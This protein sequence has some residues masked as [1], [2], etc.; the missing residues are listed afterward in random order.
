[1]SKEGVPLQYD[2]FSGDLVDNRTRKQKKA[3]CQKGQ[4]QQ[5]VMFSQREVAQFGVRSNP[6]MSLSEHTKLVLISEDPRTPEEI[7]RDIQREIEAQ[8]HHLFTEHPE[9]YEPSPDTKLENL[10]EDKI[11]DTPM[12]NGTKKR[13]PDASK[14]TI[15]FDLVR[16]SEENAETIW[17]APPYDTAYLTQIAA[18]VL[19]AQ[20]IG[21]TQPEITAA[22][23]I[24]QH[25][26]N[27]RKTL[28]L[29][30]QPLSQ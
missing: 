6:Q 23:Q 2:L 21:L 1:M 11:G 15:Y 10:D 8:T 30:S 18:T 24:G 9:F 25:R 28:Y 7:E 27:T 22:I 3:D 12:T 26:G 14:V 5:T 4:P 20:A 19:E 13:K 17:I 16:L 29:A